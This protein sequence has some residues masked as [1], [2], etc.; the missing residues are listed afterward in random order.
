MNANNIKKQFFI[1]YLLS[2]INSTFYLKYFLNYFFCLK[3]GV[4]LALKFKI[5]AERAS[6]NGSIWDEFNEGDCVCVCPLTSC[7]QH[8]LPCFESAGAYALRLHKPLGRIVDIN[9][10]KGTSA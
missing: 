8:M 7:F 6:T 5:Y 2:H 4:N 10:T 3:F 1:C 9:Y